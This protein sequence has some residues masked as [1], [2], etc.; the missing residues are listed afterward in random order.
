MARGIAGGPIALAAEVLE[1]NP[2]HAFY[3]RVGYKPVAWSVRLGTDGA[4]WPRNARFAGPKDALPIT[5]L[6]GALLARRRTVGDP[7]FDPPRAVDAT[8]LDAVAAYLTRPPGELPAEI[9]ALDDQ[10]YVR[11]SGTLLV[12]HLDPPF[13]SANRAALCRVSVDPAIAPEAFIR[14]LVELGA[15]VARRHGARTLEVTD[16]SPPGTPIHA[17]ALGC[18]AIAWSRIVTKLVS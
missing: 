3:A 13:V 12:M 10:G 8:A 5:L 1:P 7:R 15:H 2:A 17:A 18:G 9:V 4:T 16:L 6:D 11:A 14:T